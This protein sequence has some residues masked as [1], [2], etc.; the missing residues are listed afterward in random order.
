MPVARPSIIYIPENNSFSVSSA[1]D[2]SPG[3]PPE[4]EPEDL[5]GYWCHVRRCFAESLSGTSEGAM[6]DWT[7][8]QSSG[9]VEEIIDREN[10]RMADSLASKVTRLKSVSG[11]PC[12]VACFTL[13]GGAVRGEKR[14]RAVREDA[15]S[16]DATAGL[17]H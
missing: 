4:A 2:R 7:R 13:V 9:A 6:A 1:A 12:S 15:D 5:F 16:S 10:K 3:S 8:T 11:G 14:P 17:G